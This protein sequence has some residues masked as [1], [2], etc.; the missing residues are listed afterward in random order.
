VEFFIIVLVFKVYSLDFNAAI[1]M[2]VLM[3]FLVD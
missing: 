2:G 1:M 3:Y